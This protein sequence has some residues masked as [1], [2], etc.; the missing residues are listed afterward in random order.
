M[1]FEFLELIEFQDKKYVIFLP[2]E[3]EEGM[4]QIFEVQDTD[5]TDIE[6]YVSVEDEA[7]LYQV[8]EIFKEK[9]KDDFEFMD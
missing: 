6:M 2:V 4:V 5:E 3:S 8:F 7:V 9:F 1:P